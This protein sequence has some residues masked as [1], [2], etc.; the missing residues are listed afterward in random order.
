MR[1]VLGRSRYFNSTTIGPSL[2]RLR[3]SRNRPRRSHALRMPS[4]KHS[5]KKA[6]TSKTVDLPLPFGPS[7]TVSGVNSFSVTSRSA[8]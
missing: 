3:S 7:S 6:N 2:S 4:V 1:G 8:R 5:D